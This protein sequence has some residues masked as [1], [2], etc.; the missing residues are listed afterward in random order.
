MATGAATAGKWIEMGAN[1]PADDVD[2]EL[3]QLSA[4][5][6]A[7]CTAISRNDIESLGELLAEDYVHVH[8]TGKIDDKA[9][10]LAAFGRSPRI[11]WRDGIKVRRIGDTA[12]IVGT[13][14]NERT[15][16][17]GS[18]QRTSAS[19]T[20]IL[21]RFEDGRWRFVLFHGCPA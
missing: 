2:E 21:N 18:A 3:D 7:R 5:E 17:G 19:V 12:V 6:A 4:L 9:G 1:A 11:C 20:T 14:I 15:E 10:A 13:Q 8:L 16:P